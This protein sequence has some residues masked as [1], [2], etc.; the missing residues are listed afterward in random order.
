MDKVMTS[1]E[2]ATGM[3]RSKYPP[4]IV[5][6]LV[7]I[8]VTVVDQ[9]SKQWAFSTLSDSRHTMLFGRIL[10]LVLMCNPGTAF[11]FAAG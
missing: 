2:G 3:R 10:G 11:S 7:M 8:V 1:R 9:T 4:V 6:W 5:L